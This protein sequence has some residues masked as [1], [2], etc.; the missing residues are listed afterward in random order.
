MDVTPLEFTGERFTPE[1]VR[2][3]WYEHMHRYALAAG[4]AERKRV[5]DAAC[6]E[7][8]GSAM[9]ADRAA[10]VIGLD[11]DASTIAHARERY[12]DR[13]NLHFEQADVAELSQFE[14]ASFDLVTSFE[15]LEHLQPQ[16]RMLDGFKRLLRADGL[17]LVS[18]PD[19]AVY[20]DQAGFNNEFHVRELYRHEFEAMLKARF[21]HVRLLGQ[22]LM[23]ASV[24]WQSDGRPNWSAATAA[25][26][27]NAAGLNLSPMY[28]VAACSDS[29]DTLSALP[30]AHIF[31]DA[32]ES[33]YRHYEHEIRKNMSAGHRILELED[34]VRRLRDR[35]SELERG[36]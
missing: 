27:D 14:A 21:R 4:L 5:L 11:I 23:F 9:L 6:G 19:K 36:Q 32:E 29:A 13:G 15:T 24:M 17:L 10:E 25:G 26:G 8:Y 1:C 28:W 33:V 3:I 34:E 35:L 7:G 2:E 12:A 18:T 16:E 20:S 30:G 31:T 22:K